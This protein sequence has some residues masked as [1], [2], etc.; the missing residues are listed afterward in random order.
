[1]IFGFLPVG[2]AYHAAYSVLCAVMMAMLVK[3]AWPKHLEAARNRRGPEHPRLLHDSRR[4]H[5]RLPGRH[6]L[7]WQHRLP[8][9]PGQH[10]GFLSGQPLHRLD[11][12]FS[13]PL[14]HQHDGLRHSGQFGA[15]LP[16]GHWHLRH[17]GLLLLLCHSPD[18]F[19]HRHA[20][21]G[22]W[23]KNSATRPRFHFSATAGNATTS[24]PPFSR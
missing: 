18:H 20:A 4:C 7:H 22:D 23:A 15:V 3:V 19:F 2:L 12:F 13:L 14:C 24:A 8:A 1:M 16:A 5:L 9:G 21:V 10:G 17:D 11:G 6:C